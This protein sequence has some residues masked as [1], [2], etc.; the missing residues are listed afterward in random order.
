MKQVAAFL[1]WILAICFAAFLI[2]ASVL[3]GVL[4]AF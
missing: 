4:I 1:L 2:A 3:R